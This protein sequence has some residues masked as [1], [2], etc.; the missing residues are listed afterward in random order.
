M[1]AYGEQHE[2]DW[3]VGLP[4][5]MFAARESVQESLG[6]SPFDLVFGHLVRGPL[7]LVKKNNG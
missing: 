7:K 5:L 2:K 4:L 1:R 6:F 3:E